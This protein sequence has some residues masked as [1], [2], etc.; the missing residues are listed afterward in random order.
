MF[1]L[2]FLFNLAVNHPSGNS[3]V[4]CAA[5]FPAREGKE[6]VILNVAKS[7]G[8]VAPSPPRYACHLSRFNGRAYTRKGKTVGLYNFFRRLPFVDNLYLSV[9]LATLTE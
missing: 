6:Y 5:T 9:N 7:S 2:D 3:S 4:G 8:Q 1:R